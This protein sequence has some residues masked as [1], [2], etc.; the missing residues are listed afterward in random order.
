[1]EIIMVARECSLYNSI[2]QHIKNFLILKLYKIKHKVQFQ[3]T[4]AHGQYGKS[5]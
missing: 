5:I 3:M 1:M 4:R 2:Y